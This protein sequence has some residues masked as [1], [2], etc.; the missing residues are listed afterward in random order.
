MD[1][2]FEEAYRR[3]EFIEGRATNDPTDRGGPTGEGGLSLRYLRSLGTA[4]DIDGDGDVDE[5]DL[6][7]V[8]PQ[9]RR[10]FY[11]KSFWLGANCHKLAFSRTLQIKVYDTAVN[12][13]PKVAQR[14]LQQAY[15][16]HFRVALKVD[17]VLGEKSIAAMKAEARLDFAILEAYR[18]QQA[19]FYFEVVR[20]DTSQQKYAL[21]WKRRAY[22]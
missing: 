5:E 1:I 9:T 10:D 13:G 2:V 16:E 3:T 19:D 17:G 20:K 21:G 6:R 15:N 14:L 7:L 12:A 18:Q 4:G 8:S 22:T 11:H